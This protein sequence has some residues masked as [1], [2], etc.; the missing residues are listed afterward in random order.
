MKNNSS[1]NAPPSLLP[2]TPFTGVE[3]RGTESLK[4]P[5]LTSP[6]ALG[7]TIALVMREPYIRVVQVFAF[8]V[9]RILLGCS[10]R[11]LVWVLSLFSSYNF[12][13]LLF[14]FI[15]PEELL[16]LWIAWRLW[17]E[18]RLRLRFLEKCV[19]RGMSI[20]SLFC[21]KRGIFSW[22]DVLTGYIYS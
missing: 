22:P 11:S 16:K 4:S 19:L 10:R 13:K 12:I 15:I 1:K 2:P 21:L 14:L 9:G 17:V 20:L 5:T 8:H 18:S 7:S 3:L 6:P